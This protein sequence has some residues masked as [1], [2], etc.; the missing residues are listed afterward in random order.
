MSQV[1]IQPIIMQRADPY[2]VRYAPGCYYFTASVPEY[3]RIELRR[4]DTIQALADSDPVTVWKKHDSG[5]MSYNVWAPELHYLDGRWYIYFA[6]SSREDIWKIRPYV[7]GCVGPDPMKDPWQEI[8]PL[9]A[10]KKDSD[11]FKDFSLDVTIFEHN[12]QKYI[13][14]AQKVGGQ[15]AISNLY[16]SKLINPWTVSSERILL[17]EPEYSWETIGFKVNEGAAVLKRNNRIFVTFSASA[18]DSNYCVGLLWADEDSDLMQPSSWRKCAGPV[19]KTDEDVQMYG[20]GHNSF[21]VDE[22]GND[23][24]VYH[25][26][27]YRE[28]QGDPL[29][30]PNRHTFVSKIRWENG[31]PVFRY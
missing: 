20:P 18:T 31:M 11:L 4:A 6:A 21:T 27:K 12:A 7:L 10:D 24:L 17:S 9:Q 23:I 2:I 14:W 22:Q 30:D 28:I 1:S 19:L 3:D 15:F 29:Y 13:I 25:A 26:R 16:L 5:A 8:G